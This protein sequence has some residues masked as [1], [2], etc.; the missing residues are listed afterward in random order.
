MG[1][2]LMRVEKGY[3]NILPISRV[4]SDSCGIEKKISLLEASNLDF[5]KKLKGEMLEDYKIHMAAAY[6][7]KMNLDIRYFEHELNMFFEEHFFENI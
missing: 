5:L 7:A 4:P 2:I 6:Q 3:I 1:S